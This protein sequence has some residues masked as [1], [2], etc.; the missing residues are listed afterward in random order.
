M[1]TALAIAALIALAPSLRADWVI[2]QNTKALGKD[3]QMTIKVKGDHIRNEIGQKMTVFMD[4]SKGTSKMFMHEQKMVMKMNADSIK[5]AAGLANKFLGGG[6]DTPAKPK[7][8]GE[9]VK[10]GEWETEVYTWES[11]MGSGKFYVVKSFPKFEELSQAMDRITKSMSNPMSAMF[12]S[13]HDFP[14][15]I[16]KSEMTMMGQLSSTELVS[17]KEEPVADADFVEPE[18]YQEMKMP[19]LPGGLGK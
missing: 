10:V 11:K 18:G 5:A 14:G 19:T 13:Y 1:K 9:K 2:I 4:V 15:M 7:A 3:S 8:T 12:P 16:V 6:N 17:A